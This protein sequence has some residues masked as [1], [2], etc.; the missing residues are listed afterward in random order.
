M[1]K[2]I[3]E[4]YQRFLQIKDADRLNDPKYN[5][6]YSA[7]ERELLRDLISMGDHDHHTLHGITGDYKKQK[8]KIKNFANTYNV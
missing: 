8:S 5:S 4:L 3:P 1:K 7:K 6:N 2:R